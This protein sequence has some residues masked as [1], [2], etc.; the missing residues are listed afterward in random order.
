M[1]SRPLLTKIQIVTVRIVPVYL[2]IYMLVNYNAPCYSNTRASETSKPKT[3]M[4][5]SKDR[6]QYYD[7]KCLQAVV[8]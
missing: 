3:M 2:G 5:V 1:G 8:S 6:R 4:K 7:S